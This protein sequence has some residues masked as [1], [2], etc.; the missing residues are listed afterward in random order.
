MGR[1]LARIAHRATYQTSLLSF[2]ART[3]RSALP[4]CWPRPRGRP[5]P[6]L[7]PW[8]ARSFPAA[9][10]RAARSDLVAYMGSTARG[11]RPALSPPPSR[12]PTA[13]TA[14]PPPPHTPR[15]AHFPAP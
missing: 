14:P 2:D 15:P 1:T 7:P 8:P 9:A 12:L 3:L 11:G 4:P 10:R 6:L 13:P 5:G